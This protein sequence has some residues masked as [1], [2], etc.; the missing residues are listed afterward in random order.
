VNRLRFSKAI[1][2]TL[3][4]LIFLAR[5][6]EGRLV[7]SRH[8]ARETG[9][10]ENHLGTLL[11][12]LVRADIVF[13][14]RGSKGGYRLTRPAAR[15]TLLDVVEAVQ[16]PIWIDLPLEEGQPLP[17]LEKIWQQMVETMRTELAKIAVADL[18]E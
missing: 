12:S 14:L 15:I 18:V 1:R 17:D 7:F 11:D 6:E 13:A 5:Q 8:I 9:T 16:G 2:Y 3:R 4:A 10:P